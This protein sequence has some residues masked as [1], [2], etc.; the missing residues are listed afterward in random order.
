M[1]DELAF[2]IDTMVLK[3]KY[4]EEL[5]WEMQ[6]MFLEILATFLETYW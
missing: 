4:F 2:Y 3:S 5:S 6:C 1:L